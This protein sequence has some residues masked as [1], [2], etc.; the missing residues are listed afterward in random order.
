VCVALF[1]VLVEIL[2]ILG[3]GVKDARMGRL[4]TV[5]QSK[6]SAPPVHVWHKE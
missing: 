6:K 2:G 1:A 3:V 5:G 4:C